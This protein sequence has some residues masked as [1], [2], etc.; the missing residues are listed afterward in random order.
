MLFLVLGPSS[1]TAAPLQGDLELEGRDL[2]TSEI[3]GAGKL[4]GEASEEPGPITDDSSIMDRV[5]EQLDFA[6]EDCGTMSNGEQIDSKW[7]R[8]LSSQLRADIRSGDIKIVEFDAEEAGKSNEGG[9]E[10]AGIADSNTIGLS[11]DEVGGFKDNDGNP[12]DPDRVP[13]AEY[14]DV[15]GTLLH[16]YIHT[17]EKRDGDDCEDNGGNPNG[18]PDL[19]GNPCDCYHSYVYARDLRYRQQLACRIREV[20]SDDDEGNDREKPDFRDYE[21]VHLNWMKFR[22]SCESQESTTGTPL[23]NQPGDGAS[24]P[25]HP[26]SPSNPDGI[27]DFVNYD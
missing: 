2:K 22:E 15:A 3:A 12:R 23:T 9:T 7:L 10:P 5:L 20:N 14:A 13:P 16:E 17:R 19:K 1:A 25:F 21:A 6:G 8:D 24:G 26:K 11:S 27:P 18:L 4:L